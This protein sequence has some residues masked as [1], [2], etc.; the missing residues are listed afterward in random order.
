MRISTTD[1]TNLIATVEGTSSYIAPRWPRYVDFFH[2]IHNKSTT[3]PSEQKH[4]WR[5]NRCNQEDIFFEAC[6]F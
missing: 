5:L 2:L 6:V 1:Y 4:Q 3:L